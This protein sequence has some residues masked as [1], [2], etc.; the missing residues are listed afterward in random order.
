[1][2]TRRSKGEGSID[3]TREGL[4]RWRGY[5]RDPVTGESVRKTIKAKTR[6]QL[7]EKV[8]KWK[9]GNG[10]VRRIRVE[11]MSPI[12]AESSSKTLKP[13]TL[14]DYIKTIK[15][16]VILPFR[17]RYID[18]ITT[19]D[20]QRYLS[21]LTESHETITIRSIRARMS[22]FFEFAKTAGYIQKNPVRAVKMPKDSKPRKMR[23]LTTS[24]VQGLLDVA[25]TYSY[26]Q[27]PRDPQ[28]KLMARQNYMIVLIAAITGM[29]Q[30]EILALQWTDI[31]A[32]ARVITVRASLQNIPQTTDGGG[33]RRV[34][35]KTGKTRRVYISSDLAQEVKDWKQQQDEYAKKFRGL[36]RNSENFVFTNTKGSAVDSTRFAARAFRPMLRA[37]G[38]EGVRF[39]DLRHYTAS[40]M[41]SQGVPIR[42]VSEQLGHAS[43]DITLRIYAEMI[44][45]MNDKLAAAVDAMP[46]FGK[47]EAVGGGD[48]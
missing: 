10:N 45:E 12:F 40:W 27:Q 28:E 22:V 16:H 21:N 42:A 26:R 18:S 7:S 23:I 37:A 11:E 32:D 36:F 17:G 31:D 41:I 19:L 6:K 8:E 48:P 29:R 35:T 5:A 39:H 24:E 38:I 13:K 46:L 47:K 33:R 9:S 14:R 44:S 2:A 30:G 3:K 43:S 25:K 15:N 4:F 34:T 20:I 1:M